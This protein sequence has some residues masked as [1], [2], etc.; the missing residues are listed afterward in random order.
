MIQEREISPISDVRDE[1][2]AQ[3]KTPHTLLNG[4]IGTETKNN[5]NL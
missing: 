2:L 4:A 1:S 5:F 3:V